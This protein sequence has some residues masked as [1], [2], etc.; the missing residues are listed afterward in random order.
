MVT[1]RRSANRGES[2]K[3]VPLNGHRH[4]DASPATEDKRA[5]RR[6]GRR[7]KSGSLSPPPRG[8]GRKQVARKATASTRRLTSRSPSTDRRAKASNGSN[9]RRGAKLLGYRRACR[10]FVALIACVAIGLALIPLLEPVYRK[11]ASRIDSG[12]GKGFNFTLAERI[13]QAFFSY[14]RVGDAKD[15][16]SSKWKRVGANDKGECSNPIVGEEVEAA[17]ES[18]VLVLRDILESEEA[19]ESVSKSAEDYFGI[20]EGKMAVEVFSRNIDRI[21]GAANNYVSKGLVALANG[22]IKPSFIALLEEEYRFFDSNMNQ[23]RT[24]YKLFKSIETLPIICPYS[25]ASSAGILHRNVTTGLEAF[26]SPT[27]IFITSDKH[28]LRFLQ[29]QEGVNATELG[30]EDLEEEDQ[31]KLWQIL[32]DNFHLLLG[33]SSRM[34]VE[35]TLSGIFGI[36]EPLNGASAQQIYD[37]LLFKLNTTEYSPLSLNKHFGIDML[38]MS[39]PASGNISA[40]GNASSVDGRDGVI[41]GVKPTFMPDTLFNL[42]DPRWKTNVNKL[43]DGTSV[44]ID[45]YSN[46]IRALEIRRRQFK[47]LGAVATFQETRVPKAELTP[48]PEME[49]L[50]AAALSGR[51]NDKD[52]QIFQ[53]HMLMEMARMSVEDGLVMQLHTGLERNYHKNFGSQ[54][55]SKADSGN[56]AHQNN[57]DIPIA[58]D[59]SY[60]LQTLLNTYGNHPNLTLVLFTHD[61]STYG[62]ELAPLAVQ[63]Q[64]IKV[65]SPLWFHENPEGIRSFLDSV[66]GSCGIVNL[67]GYI[68]NSHHYLQIPG[69]HKIWRKVVSDWVAKLVLE[70]RV[71]EKDAF[72]MARQLAYTAVKTT[73]KV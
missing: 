62:R 3:A 33:T 49:A 2:S 52:A 30:R 40:L 34:W 64:S 6:E 47:D 60:G 15:H 50:F 24:A 26:G 51:T 45:S 67:A 32:G 31:R 19:L 35:Q 20:K 5:R 63:Y 41:A 23:R 44:K 25:Q 39:F 14:L 18:K 22:V 17:N 13:E 54:A 73:Y 59:F 9:L 65:G 48:L 38:G 46:F 4:C 61:E 7:T 37:V 56:S 69:R 72:E 43:G 21:A 16:A 8:R 57:V 12:I 10:G 1:T 55:G 71:Q 29:S 11:V 27:D 66:V 28:I 53:N 42:K 70:G 36:H 58:V 68:D